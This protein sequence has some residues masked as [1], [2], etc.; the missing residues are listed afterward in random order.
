MLMGGARKVRGNTRGNTVNCR[1]VEKS[2]LNPVPL[3]GTLT[4]LYRSVSH[5]ICSDIFFENI[6]SS[7]EQIP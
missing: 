1:S 4:T 5:G 2:V 7:S 6:G 3:R